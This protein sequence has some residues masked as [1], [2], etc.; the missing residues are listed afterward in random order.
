MAILRQV[1][2]FGGLI[3]AAV[4][5]Y[6]VSL[7]L[8]SPLKDIPGPF[9]AKFSNLW[10]IFDYYKLTQP[11]TQR[12][13]HAKYGPAVR[14][15]PNLVSLNDPALVDVIYNTRGTFRKVCRG[16]PFLAVPLT[17]EPIES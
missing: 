12:R 8:A 6:Y 5:V 4:L 9:L 17:R 7:Y 13:L 16:V 10:R 14:L 1:V 15:G 2:L 11:I 3:A